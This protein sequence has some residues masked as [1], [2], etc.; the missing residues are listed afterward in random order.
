MLRYLRVTKSSNLNHPLYRSDID[1]LRAIAV[2]SVVGFHAFPNWIKGGFIGVDIFFVI[3]GFLISSIILNGLNSGSF[4]FIEFYVRRVKRIFPALILVMTACYV[5]GW[6]AL[7]PDEYKQLGKHIAAGAGFVSNFFFWQEAGYF[8]NAAETKPLLHL[9][10]LGIEEQF[11]IIWPLLLFLTRKWRF[12]FLMLTLTIIAISFTINTSIRHS[13]QIQAFYSP[14]TRFWELLI[15]SVLA[16]F[17]LYEVSVFDKL[18]QF[19]Y[20]ANT[21]PKRFIT[22]THNATTLIGILLIGVAVL[23]VTK[24]YA[25]PGFWALLPTIGAY[26]IISAGRDAWLNRALLSHPIL[27]WLGL[28][29]YPLYLWHWP[30]L[31]YARIMESKTPDMSSRFIAILIAIGLAWLTYR[32]IEHPLRFGKQ[33]FFKVWILIFVMIGL[34][35]VGII[36]FVQDGFKQ[37]SGVQKVINQLDELGL[38]KHWKIWM[39]C[40]E[41][42][43]QGCR[44]MD[45]KKLPDVALLG[46]SHAME[47]VFGLED[48]FR[49]LDK[50]IIARAKPSCSPFF[51][52][53]LD[54]S[55]FDSCDGFMEKALVL[56]ESSPSIKAIILGGRGVGTIEGANW[57][58]NANNL[59][60]EELERRTMSYKSALYATLKRLVKSGKK[61]IFMVDI[62][63][64]NFNPDECISKRPLYLFGHKLK[65][66]CAVPLKDFKDRSE[67]YH[68]IIAEAKKTFPEVI[69]IDAYKYFCDDNLCNAI[70]SGELMYRD[71]HHL[72]R[73]GS[74]FLARKMAYE[75][76]NK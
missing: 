67:R 72:N 35:A 69:F 58:S 57:Q 39:P 22:I 61:I 4:S 21:A 9:W 45:I 28:I 33:G 25:F 59:S 40:E 16:Y 12:N 64:L 8:D 76:L 43:S 27:A 54:K 73:K 32:F 38:A 74:L 31:A 63:E 50:N 20:K 37:R 18:T 7:L 15:G 42:E 48:L 5:F 1:G 41:G 11:Y 30:L 17:T 49:P 44:I 53:G 23:L 46:D 2:L 14:I 70:I 62:P 71:N 13:D 29:S 3:S 55:V 75:L 51:E 47:L 26:L 36:T 10:S 66:P 68:R 34:G 60:K 65:S 56:T 6:F 52:T 24:E 19:F